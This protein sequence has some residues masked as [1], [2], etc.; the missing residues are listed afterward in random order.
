MCGCIISCQTC[1]ALLL[2]HRVL[3]GRFLLAHFANFLTSSHSSKRS[4]VL[5]SVANE[6]LNDTDAG[7]GP[8]VAAALPGPTC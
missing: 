1:S 6:L 5:Y 2:F 7:N 3:P 8:V 4:V